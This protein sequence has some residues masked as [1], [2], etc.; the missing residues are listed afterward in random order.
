MMFE[1]VEDHPV[2]RRR[3][4]FDSWQDMYER[5]RERG[6]Y[7]LWRD[8]IFRDYCEHGVVP[9]ADGAGV[10]LA[11]PP[12][13]EATIYMHHFDVDLYAMM[14][15]ISQP[16]AILRAKERDPD[17]GEMDFSSSPTAPDLA[18][19]FPNATDVYLPE[20]THFIPMQEPEMVAR[21]IEHENPKERV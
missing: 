4:H 6:S 1:R 7:P 11:C 13:V 9:S 19:V 8:D 10:D 16:V 14:P 2:A 21:Y 20:L 17:A 15:D 3:G 12:T 18:Q 5:Y